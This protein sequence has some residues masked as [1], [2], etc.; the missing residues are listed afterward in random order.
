MTPRYPK[1]RPTQSKAIKPTFQLA[2]FS[3]QYFHLIHTPPTNEPNPTFKKRVRFCYLYK[4][5][6]HVIPWRDK[7]K[8]KQPKNHCK[9]LPFWNT[10]RMILVSVFQIQHRVNRSI[11]RIS[12]PFLIQPYLCNQSNKKSSKKNS[13]TCSIAH[14]QSTPTRYNSK[15]SSLLKYN[16]SDSILQI[17]HGL[18]SI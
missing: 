16:L 4:V 14:S 7:R 2:T 3:L 5:P 12:T 8:T 18:F 11:L 1:A 10:F 9:S 6:S 15:I 17:I 13:Q